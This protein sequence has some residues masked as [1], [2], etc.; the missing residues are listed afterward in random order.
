MAAE[1][2]AVT[3]TLRANL[4]DYESALKAAVRATERAAKSAEAAVSNI[5]KKASAAPVASAFTKST[6]QMANDARV[7]QFQLNDIFSGLASGQGIR[8]V[9]QQLGQI[10]QQMG[11]GG[12]AAGA[13]TLASAF[14]GMINPVNIAVVAFGVL[15]TVAASYF[16]D[17]EKDAQKASDELDK[18]ADAVQKLADKYG[19]LF[20]ELERVATAARKQADAAGEAVAKQK[21][22]EGAYAETQKTIGGVS[23]T[24]ELLVAALS[25]I[26]APTETIQAIRDAFDNLDQ[27]AQDFKATGAD[28]KPIIEGLN[29]IIKTQTGAV[30]ELAKQIRDTLVGAYNELERAAGSAAETMRAAGETGRTTPLVG[31]DK[32]LRTQSQTLDKALGKAADAIDGFVERVIQAES[33]G[34]AGAKNPQSSALGAGQFISSTWLSVFKQHFAKEAEGMSD[35]AILALRTDVETNRRMIRA[36]ATD[37]AKLLIEAGQEVNEA[38]LQLAHFLGAGGAIKVLQAPRG[39]PVSQILSPEAIAANKSI[40]GGGATREDVLA[41]AERRTRAPSRQKE[42]NQDLQ[43]WLKL[44]KEDLD[45]KNKQLD[46]DA[47][48]WDSQARRQAQMEEQKLIQEGLNAAIKEHGEVT[49]EDRAKI[50]AAAHAQ[51]FAGVASEEAAE[52]MKQ[53]SDRQKESAQQWQEFAQQVQGIAQSALGGLVNDLRNG[54]EAG[55]AFK[56]MLD[57]ILDSLIQIGIQMLTKN[58]FG[59]LFGGFSSGFPAAPGGLFHGG[60]TVGLSSHNDNR[61]FPPSLWAGAPHFAGGGFVG[62]RPG[63]VPIIAHAGEFVVPNAQRLA[64]SGGG[65]ID[66][67]VHQDNRINVNVAES[68]FVA[69]NHDDA[70]AAGEEINKAVQLVLVRESRPGGLLRRMPR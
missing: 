34:R 62:L 46:I 55:Q 17:T 1:D 10:A 41:Y 48:F 23:D 36:Y 59:G 11:G 63:E 57:R 16:S 8:A 44:S 9:Q 69:A 26:G 20:P 49:D 24:V 4:K 15:A 65:R 47:R 33:R 3:V 64:G 25:E 66:Q 39:T 45:L 52:K 54:V 53:A 37:N 32:I 2:A 29:D 6:Q 22:L 42:A 58:L 35:A 68:G 30:A 60:G 50:E 31:A 12:L 5:G 18:Q 67:S 28:L 43:D 19:G 7:L 51:A 61:R 56:N 38:S 40:L 14:V 21:A 70:K 27:K 13:R